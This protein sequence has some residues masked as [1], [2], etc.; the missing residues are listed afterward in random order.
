M[1]QGEIWRLKKGI[2]DFGQNLEKVLLQSDESLKNHN[3]SLREIKE[4]LGRLR[5]AQGVIFGRLD[6]LERRLS[7]LEKPDETL[8]LVEREED[9]R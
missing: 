4:Q 5:E 8:P 7:Y 3:L 6:Q 2:E 1:E 9:R